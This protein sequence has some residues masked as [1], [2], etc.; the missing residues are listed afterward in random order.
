[1][2]KLYEFIAGQA[3]RASVN[4]SLAVRL[5]DYAFLILVAFFQGKKGRSL[6]C[7]VAMALPNGVYIIQGEISLVITAMRRTTR[8]GSH[9]RHVSIHVET[10]S[11]TDT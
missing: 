1:M 11:D 8:Y 7:C 2:R 10:D 6:H 9:G 4:S 5:T 3:S